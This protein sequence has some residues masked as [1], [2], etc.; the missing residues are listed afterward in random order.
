MQNR[1][2]IAR[3]FLALAIFLVLS[4]PARAETLSPLLKQG[5][6][7]EWWFVFK[8]NAAKF[9]GCGHEERQCIF[10]GSV[11]DYSA[12]GQQFVYASNVNPHLQQGQGCVGDTLTDPVG[13][14]FDEIYNGHFYYVIW[15]DQF[16][17]DPLPQAG[18]PWGHSK[19]ILAWDD[20]GSG[21]VMQVTTPSWPASGSNQ[22]PRLTDGNT[23]GCTKNNSVRFSQHFF[24]LKLNKDDVVK[25]LYAL[26][27][28]SVATDP[29]N[30][31]IVRNGGS[32]DIQAL[33]RSLGFKSQGKAP[34]KQLLSSGV[35][36]IS[37]PSQLHVPPWQMVSALLDG[38]PLRVASWWNSPRI[39]A[40]E[41]A[42]DIECWDESL[43]QPGAVDIATAG[44]WQETE[45][46]LKG[47]PNPNSNHAK[48]G[49]SMDERYPYTIFGD[50]NQQGALSGKC[51]SSQNGRG[52]LFF[53]LDQPV[54]FTDVIALIN[55]NNM[56]KESGHR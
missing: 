41:E 49:V 15:N 13:S 55:G 45:F 47:S 5:Q 50:L 35:L 17:D 30:P 14:T 23:L 20:T 29:H 22:S 3:V 11:Q 53:V 16:Y 32:N 25:V 36:L 42:T 21:L 43:H 19:G 1:D 10:G 6:P 52:G 51:G 26:Q 2:P 44:H 34:S 18:S 31:Q 9:P 12:F 4:I 54:L 24:S 37:K 46:G 7:V 56:Y 33:V 48:I 27:Y 38:I 40:T 8:F 28:A 39:P